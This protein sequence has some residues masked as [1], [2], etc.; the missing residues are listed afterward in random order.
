MFVVLPLQLRLDEG[1]SSAL[2]V[3]GALM[4]VATTKSQ[5]QANEPKMNLPCSSRSRPG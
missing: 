2:V 5:H 1:S 4:K 3:V